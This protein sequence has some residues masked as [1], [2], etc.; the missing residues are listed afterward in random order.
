M[1]RLLATM[2][3]LK[4]ERADIQIVCKIDSRI[5]LNFLAS[6]SSPQFPNFPLS[7]CLSLSLQLFQ[8][9]I[10]TTTMVDLQPTTKSIQGSRHKSKPI[11]HQHPNE[12]LLGSEIGIQ[13][14]RCATHAA[15]GNQN[16]RIES[17]TEYLEHA[18]G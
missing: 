5:S 11:N 17:A 16:K 8:Y 18:K 12:Q 14:E 13:H 6:L 9:L 10:L 4:R 2:V 7:S 15:E 1:I 3:D